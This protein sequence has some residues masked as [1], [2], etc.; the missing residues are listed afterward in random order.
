MAAGIHRSNA[1]VAAAGPETRAGLTHGRPSEVRSKTACRGADAPWAQW[2]VSIRSGGNLG[3]PRSVP[4]GRGAGEVRLRR[5][6][7]TAATAGVGAGTPFPLRWR[8]V[9]GHPG[10]GRY[11]GR[12]TGPV[13]TR[14]ACAIAAGGT[15]NPASA[16]A[17]ASCRCC[18]GTLSPARPDL[19]ARAGTGQRPSVSLPRRGG[20][21]GLFAH[22]CQTSSKKEGQREAQ[23]LSREAA[24][25]SE[26]ECV[27]E[28]VISCVVCPA[29]P[30]SVRPPVGA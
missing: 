19:P 10:F 20:R 8:A 1:D 13:K 11:P 30:A 24:L 22:A 12:G 23:A 7:G 18:N 26:G 17:D 6:R 4:S 28:G 5:P 29:V 9:Q 2:R 14:P 16:G 25:K 27:A 3:A 15:H 21:V